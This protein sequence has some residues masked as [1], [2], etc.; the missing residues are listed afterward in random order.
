MELQDTEDRWNYIERYFLGDDVIGS[1]APTDFKENRVE[2]RKMIDE[3]KSTSSLAYKDW[4]NASILFDDSQLSVVK[5]F[6]QAG[7]PIPQ[8]FHTKIKGG[9]LSEDPIMSWPDKNVLLFSQEATN[10]D[11]DLC[12]SKGWAAYRILEVDTKELFE[13]VV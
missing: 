10:A 6:E 1:D 5:E 13:I 3:S 9:M 2:L 12:K 4:R 11:L 7:V 8:Y